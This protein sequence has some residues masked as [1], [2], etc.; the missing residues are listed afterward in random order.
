MALVERSQ[1]MPDL[2]ARHG[3]TAAILEAITPADLQA[4]ARRYLAMDQ[5]VE[6]LALP[7][8]VEVP[9]APAG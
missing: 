5:A 6:I 8:G 2:I 1:T 7:E 3:Q 9:V 4:M